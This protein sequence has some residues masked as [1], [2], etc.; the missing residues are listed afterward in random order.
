MIPHARAEQD[1]A[2]GPV[3]CGWSITDDRLTVTVTVPPGRTAV[4]EIPTT[5]PGSVRDESGAGTLRA[6]PPATGATLRLPS[7]RFTFTATHAL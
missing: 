1:T 3:A 5:D 6:G 4:L 7:G 2:S